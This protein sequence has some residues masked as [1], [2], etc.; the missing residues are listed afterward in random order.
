MPKLTTDLRAAHG[1]EGDVLLHV[2]TGQ[3]F[4]VNSVGSRILQLLGSGAT[5]PEISKQISLEFG[6]DPEAVRNDL[7]E[8]LAHLARH[9]IVGLE[10]DAQ[11]NEATGENG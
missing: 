1:T 10:L 7:A 9:K 8:F 4:A 5:Q 3:M 2:G 6:V 11:S